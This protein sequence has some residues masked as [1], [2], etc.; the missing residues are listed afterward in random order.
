MFCAHP[1]VGDDKLVVK[2]ALVT[3]RLG[4]F[5]LSAT[6]AFRLGRRL[7]RDSL[8]VVTYHRV[9]A[10][11]PNG[12]TL[13]SPNSI[14]RW[15]FEQQIDYLVHYYHVVTG[16]D[17]RLFLLGGRKLPENSVFITFDDGYE[18]NFTEAFPILQRFGVPAAFFLTTDLIGR[19]EAC[20]WFDTLDWIFSFSPLSAVFDRLTRAGIP[21]AIQNPKGVRKWIKTLSRQRRDD[22]IAMMSEIL[23]RNGAHANKCA[24]S[25]LMTWDQV[26]QMADAGMTIGSHTATHQILASAN[27]DEIQLE[28]IGS[29]SKI[30]EET[31]RSCWCFAYP[32][33]GLADFKSLDK[34]ALQAAGYLCAFTQIPGFITANPDRYALPRIPIPDSGNM[35]IFASRVS[36]IHHWVQ[37][38][39]PCNREQD[40]NRIAFS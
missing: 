38:L 34:A 3:K 6:G 26:R 15:E 39:I 33:G 37:N 8:A 14:F 16:E 4:L 7:S 29:R 10:G 19:P 36:G 35:R 17:V 22:V 27:P 12:D 31:G 24:A 18:D 5:L 11:K 20:L 1:V 28:I 21:N 25:T 9:A 30:E 40:R 32:N 23:A 2:E 13:R